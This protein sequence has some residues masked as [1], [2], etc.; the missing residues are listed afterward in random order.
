MRRVLSCVAVLI[1]TVA[2]SLPRVAEAQ[3]ARLRLDSLTRLS[4]VASNVTDI[5][6]DPAM[7]Q[8]AGNFLSSQNEST[9]PAKQLLNGLTGVYVKSFE[10][11]RDNAYS[12]SD[13]ETIR[14]QFKTSPTPSNALTG[15]WHR[16]LVTEEKKN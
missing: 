11:D 3:G 15:A 13:I 14:S 12:P 7:L 4:E 2:V 16:V 1:G 8:L 9:A 10:F 6:L 5:G